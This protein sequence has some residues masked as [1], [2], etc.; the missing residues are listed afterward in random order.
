VQRWNWFLAADA[1][2]RWVTTHGYA[3]VERSGGSLEAT[4]CYPG[5]A[6]PYHLVSASL[7][8]DGEARAVV[9]SPG[10]DTPP[11]HLRGRMFSGASTQAAQAATLLLTDGTTVLGITFGPQSNQ[12]NL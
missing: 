12:P 5:T 10:R 7:E 2:G 4:L 9:S 1:S 6:T 3:D 8:A 11:F